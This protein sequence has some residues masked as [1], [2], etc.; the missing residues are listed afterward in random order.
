VFLESQ[1]SLVLLKQEKLKLEFTQGL[2][3]K[4]AV[5]ST[6]AF[7]GQLAVLSMMTVSLEENTISQ[8]CS[9]ML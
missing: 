8:W 1:T 9:R 6:K 7:L 2:G 4:V 5:A 3:L